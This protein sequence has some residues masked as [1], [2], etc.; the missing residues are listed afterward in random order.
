DIYSARKFVTRRV[1][2]T[3]RGVLSHI[4]PVIYLGLY[5]VITSI[6][7]VLPTTLLGF[8][9][10]KASV[11]YFFGANKI[12]RVV[13]SLFT[14]LTTVMV[15]RMNLIFES[16]DKETYFSLIDKSLNFII[17]FGIP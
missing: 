16:E 3:L 6:Y 5:M 1:V 14:I 4:R 17:S 2:L 8:L 12:I 11:G 7:S 15:P 10:N 13:L 9:S